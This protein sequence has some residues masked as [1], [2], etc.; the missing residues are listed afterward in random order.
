MAKATTK[1]AATAK[2]PAVK[3]P[4]TKA[5]AT[6]APAKAGQKK[7]A[8]KKVTVNSTEPIV[9]ACEAILGKLSE[10]DIEYQLQSE[11][12]WCLGSYRN[13]NN[14][15]GL[16]HMADRALIVFRE[17]LVKKTKGVNAKLID[18]IEKALK[19]R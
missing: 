11:I 5:V 13:D 4:A 3:A 1:P 10:L 15:V 12:N 7:E 2:V 17:E 18:E 14:P 16:Y 9:R 19:N 8:P 6:K